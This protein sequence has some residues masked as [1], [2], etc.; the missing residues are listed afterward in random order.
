MSKKNISYDDFVNKFK[1]KRTTDDCYPPK[2]YE[3]VLGWARQHLGIGNRPV[4]RPF[5]PGGDYERFE[6]P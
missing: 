5:Y 3:A 4:V 1:S 2:V 6:Y